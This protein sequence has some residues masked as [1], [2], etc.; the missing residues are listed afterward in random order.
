MKTARVVGAGLSGLVAAWWLVEAGYAVEVVDASHTPGGLLQTAVTPHGLVEYGANAFVWTPVVADWFA[1]LEIPPFFAS[2]TSRR[3]YIYRNGRPRRW[4]LG[5]AETA[6]LAARVTVRAAA[7]DLGARDGETVTAW[8]DRALGP[9]ATAWLV[10]P[11]LQG[12][13]AASTDRLSARAVFGGRRPGR[14]RMVAPA[15]GMG[16]FTGTLHQRLT[17]RG[18]GFQFGAGVDALDPREPTV[19]A[20]SATAAAP[21]VRPLAPSVADAM[22]AVSTAGLL[23]A[24]MFYR[25]HPSDIRGFGILFPRGQGVEALGVLFNAGIFEGRGPMRSETWIYSASERD[26]LPAGELAIL[27]VIAA[28]RRTLIGRTDEPLAA[29]ARLHKHALPIY[30]ASIAHVVTESAYL[31]PHLALAGNYLGRLGVS[32]LLEIAE[33]AARRLGA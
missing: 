12:V 5:V 22:D 20:T 14:R 29:H 9:A 1:R 7:R 4:P 2:E 28:D 8:S 11:A 18:V 21:L 33:T 19:V 25:P 27:P 15:D 10:A 13:Y 3:R 31:P 30:D 24:T 32:S 26:T 6:A 16:A 23:T 17:A